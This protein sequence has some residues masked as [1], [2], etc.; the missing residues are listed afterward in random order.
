V[1]TFVVV[2]FYAW[3]TLKLAATALSPPLSSVR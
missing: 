3:V 2:G 1:T